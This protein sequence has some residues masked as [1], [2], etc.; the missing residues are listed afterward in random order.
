[1]KLQTLICAI[2]D[3]RILYDHVTHHCHGDGTMRNQKGKQHQFDPVKTIRHLSNMH[4]YRGRFDLGFATSNSRTASACFF[5]FCFV[6]HRSADCVNARGIRQQSWQC[7][8]FAPPFS[9]NYID[10]ANQYSDLV[11]RI[12]YIYR[13]I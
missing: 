13:Y 5:L 6:W 10:Q 3:K 12:R 4:I 7:Q 11:H 1:M 9:T 8:G 2:D